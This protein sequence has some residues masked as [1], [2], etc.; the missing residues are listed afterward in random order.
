MSALDVIGFSQ[1]EVKAV[2]QILAS[3]LLLVTPDSA[4]P[5]KISASMFDPD[6]PRQGNLR[7]ESDGESV[8]IRE[9][10]AI[11]NL[12]ELTRTDPDA[13]SKS[14]LFRTV[15]TGGGEVIQ[16]GHSEQEACFGRDAFAKVLK[17]DAESGLL[18]WRLLLFSTLS[19][20]LKALYE[21]LF[22]WI[23]ARIN[24]VI[25]F[26]NYNPLLH[27]KNTVIGVLDIYG[28]EIFDNNRL[29]WEQEAPR[30]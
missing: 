24:R 5:R 3:I 4:S 30:V 12:S 29:V 26:K 10:E 7:F 27:G 11:R 1:E 17:A 15:A 8:Q 2:Y 28:F 16:K 22:S 20:L 18:R 6:C 14:L 19:H 9:L 23:V 13:F 21:R 25:E